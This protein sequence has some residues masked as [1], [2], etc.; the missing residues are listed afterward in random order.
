MC[1]SELECVFG[2]MR[3]RHLPNCLYAPQCPF[4]SICLFR[5]AS[6][7][8]CMLSAGGSRRQYGERRDVDSGNHYLPRFVLENVRSFF[9]GSSLVRLICSIRPP[10]DGRAGQKKGSETREN[11]RNH[12]HARSR[13]QDKIITTTATCSNTEYIHT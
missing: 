2:L 10:E 13:E 4:Q 1:E 9:F 12:A 3:T 5:K 8:T 11:V 7:N 6:E